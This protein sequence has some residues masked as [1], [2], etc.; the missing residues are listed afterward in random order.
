M[1]LRAVLK[2]RTGISPTRGL[3]WDY[4]L[5]KYRRTTNRTLNRVVRFRIF[6]TSRHSKNESD[7]GWIGSEKI[8]SATLLE[9]RLVFTTGLSSLALKT[10]R[11]SCGGISANLFAMP[12]RSLEWGT[13]LFLKERSSDQRQHLPGL[14]GSVRCT[15]SFMCLSRTLRV[16]WICSNNQSSSTRPRSVFRSSWAINT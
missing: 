14:S 12:N 9:S 6:C 16:G 8:F 11:Q 2:E 3:I 10:W 4:A 5:L 7:A 13:C 15:Q 1:N